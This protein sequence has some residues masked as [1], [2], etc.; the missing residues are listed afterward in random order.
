[1]TK[2]C[3]HCESRG[4]SK[5]GVSKFECGTTKV[6]KMDPV[7]SKQCLEYENDQLKFKL[8]QL[9]RE[10]EVWNHAQSAWATTVYNQA[11]EIKNMKAEIKKLT[12]VNP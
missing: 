7:R 12:E 1:M 9:S 6:A 8:S 10:R 3:P 2:Y 4:T 5:G 11:E